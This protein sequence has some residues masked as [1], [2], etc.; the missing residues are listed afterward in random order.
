M[1]KKFVSLD[2]LETFLDQIK[3]LIPTVNNPTITIKQAGTSKGSFTLNQ[4]GTTTIELTDNNTTYSA[5]TTSTAGLMSA[6]DK[7]KLDSLDPNMS[8]TVD[9]ALSATSTNPVQNKIVTGSLNSKLNTSDITAKTKP[10]LETIW[11]D[12]SVPDIA[13]QLTEIESVNATKIANEITR[14]K[15]AESAN[16]TDITNLSTKVDGLFTVVSTW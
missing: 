4:S 13:S 15:A 8:M 12:S 5:A 3:K 1:A 14:A 7:S 16:A 6:S 2:R 9:S 11:N 10:E